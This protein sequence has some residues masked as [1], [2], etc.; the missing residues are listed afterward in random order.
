MKNLK[1][2]YFRDLK[3]IKLYHLKPKIQHKIS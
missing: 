1:K 3:F 2:T